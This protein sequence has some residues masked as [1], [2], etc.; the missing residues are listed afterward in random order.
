MSATPPKPGS[1]SRTRTVRLMLPTEGNNLGSVFGGII[2]A[3]MDRVAYITA[4]RHALGPCL[5]ASFDRVDFIAPVHVGDVVQFDA[6]VTFVRRTSMEIW[7][8]VSAERLDGGPPRAV[9]SAFIT[10]VAIDPR[11]R[12]TPVP[13]LLL[14]TEEERER[15]KKGRQR[16][17]ERRRTRP[18]PGTTE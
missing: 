3:E 15:A 5:T 9:G 2:L 10:M 17:D 4:S 12:P 13:E 6:Q 11:G 1:V 8:Q 16:M 14:T 7:I 18:L